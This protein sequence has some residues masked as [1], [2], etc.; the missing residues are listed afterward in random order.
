MCWQSCRGNVFCIMQVS[1]A[2]GRA[3]LQASLGQGMSVSRYYLYPIV[4][5][6][7]MLVDVDQVKNAARLQQFDSGGNALRMSLEY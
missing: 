7:Y 1:T 5:Q 4:A 2:E 6:R 3:L